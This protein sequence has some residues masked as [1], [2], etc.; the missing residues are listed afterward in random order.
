MRAELD[1]RLLAVGVGGGRLAVHPRE[2]VLRAPVH[3]HLLGAREEVLAP[4]RLQRHRLP[5][6]GDRVARGGQA[7]TLVAE[8]LA[9]A[10]S[11]TQDT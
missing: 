10:V 6:V 1:V 2:P 11:A 3:Q 7:H 4:R 9:P 5:G 8:Q